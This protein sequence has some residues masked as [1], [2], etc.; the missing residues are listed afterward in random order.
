M[1]ASNYVHA[2]QQQIYRKAITQACVKAHVKWHHLQ[3]LAKDKFKR[4]K[5]PLVCLTSNQLLQVLGIQS[6]G[7]RNIHATPTYTLR[8]K[9]L[10]LS[11]ALFNMCM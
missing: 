5:P 3:L 9:A 7:L 11:F 2:I 6:W 4:W 10:N 1:H 8:M